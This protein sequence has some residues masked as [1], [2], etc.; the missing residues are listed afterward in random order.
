MHTRHQQNTKDADT[1]KILRDGEN[2][3]LSNIRQ[4]D[5]VT[6]QSFRSRVKAALPDH[7]RR[8]DIDL[9]RTQMDCGGVGALVALRK[10]AR[11]QNND[12]AIYL[13][14][15][16]ASVRRLFSLTRMDRLFPIELR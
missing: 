6:S 5:V 8:I 12:V 1:M 16:S 11:E 15:P 2:L 9:T 10:S 7:V 13:V 14:N 4:L 3:S